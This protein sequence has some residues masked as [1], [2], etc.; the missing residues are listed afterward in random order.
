LFALFFFLFLNNFFVFLFL[1][2]K[3]EQKR[4]SCVSV[5]FLFFCSRNSKRTETRNKKK[6]FLVLETILKKQFLVSCFFFSLFSFLPLFSLAGDAVEGRRPRR[7]VA[8][9]RR[10]RVS[11]WLGK[12]TGPVGRSPEAGDRPKKEKIKKKGKK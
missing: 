3:K 11:P 5:L 12:A 1:G 8:G 7:S 6:L 10:G 4:V 2:T 9:P